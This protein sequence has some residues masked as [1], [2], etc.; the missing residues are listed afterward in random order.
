[1]RGFLGGV[2]E[3][4]CKGEQPHLR[5]HWGQTGPRT[6]R[7]QARREGMFQGGL[8]PAGLRAQRKGF[9]RK[10]QKRSLQS[11]GED[12]L[13]CLSPDANRDKGLRRLVLS[14]GQRMLGWLGVW[15]KEK[16]RGREEPA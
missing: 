10:G 6:T 3:I 13:S 5:G 16:G 12:D 9:S 2:Q 11:H 1:M 4:V 15:G 7:L 8:G 14:L